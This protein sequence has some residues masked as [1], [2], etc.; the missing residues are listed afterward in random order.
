MLSEF[1]IHAPD[2]T[3]EASELLSEYGWD[4]TLYAG[5]TELL[6]VMREGLAAYRHLID[7]KHI[8]DIDGIQLSSDRRTLHIGAAAT[9]R[10]IETSGLVARH[11]PLVA[12]VESM[13]A[14]IRVRVAGTIGGNLCFAE[15]HSDVA[16]LLAAWQGATVT[17]ASTA[18][19]REVA[20]EAFFIDLFT[21][22]REDD[23]VM[24][25]VNVPVLAPQVGGGYQKFVT[26]E[27]PT[28]NVAAFLRLDGASIS[29]ADVAVGSVGPIPMRATEAAQILRGEEPGEDL[30]EQAAAAAARAVD[31]VSDVYGSAS[32]KRQLV[33]VLTGR[34][35]NQALVRANGAR[36]E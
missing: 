31:P 10:E 23:E 6:I 11:A 32:Y 33:R 30:F 28:A 21:T 20:I 34:A 12:D 36:N 1:E 19:A 26:L 3:E 22:A 7:V 4:A 25:A 35:L 2:T 14:N 18:G 27:R 29:G 13:V 16:T 8:P 24:T 5:G 9:H 15:P 17:L